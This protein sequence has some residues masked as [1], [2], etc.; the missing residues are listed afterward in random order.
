MSVIALPPPPALL[1]RLARVS[2]FTVLRLAWLATER[3]CEGGRETKDVRAEGGR[4]WDAGST[5]LGCERE[6]G[7]EDLVVDGGRGYASGTREEW[8]LEKRV[9]VV[10]GGRGMAAACEARDERGLGGGWMNGAENA[11]AG[12]GKSAGVLRTEVMAVGL[13]GGGDLEW[14][15]VEWRLD[16]VEYIVFRDD[17]EV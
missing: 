14:C 10:E 11:D 8:G 13:D 15:E 5:R 6:E 4:G 16:R 3:G 12:R 9:D 7:C 1:P 17:C 2:G